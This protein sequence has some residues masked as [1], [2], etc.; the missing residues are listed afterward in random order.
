MSGT[1][2]NSFLS[3]LQITL[4]HF[5]LIAC[6]VS[7]L[8]TGIGGFSTFSSLSFLAFSS[9]LSLAITVKSENECDWE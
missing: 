4:L 5:I 6:F 2:S 7:F 3:W 9:V 8:G 1:D